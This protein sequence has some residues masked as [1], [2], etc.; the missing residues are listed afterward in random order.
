MQH[1]VAASVIAA[2][3]L[4][5]DGLASLILTERMGPYRIARAFAMSAS[6]CRARDLAFVL[7]CG[8]LARYRV[9][10][11]DWDAEPERTLALEALANG[12]ARTDVDADSRL[13]KISEKANKFV[14]ARWHEINRAAA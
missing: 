1:A 13:R 3:A 12:P 4:G 9:A 14:R 7:V 2:R 5:Y 10:P 8:A 11:K 6:F